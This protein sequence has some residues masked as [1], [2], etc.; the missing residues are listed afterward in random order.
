[1]L[2][3]PCDLI[4]AVPIFSDLGFGEVQPWSV[5]AC[6]VLV[7]SLHAS[8]CSLPLVAAL[9]Y[10][11]AMMIDLITALDREKQAAGIR[12]LESRDKCSK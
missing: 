4:T 5:L 7:L 3:E 6:I 11:A 2:L 9:M 1:M 10:Y 8:S 12:E